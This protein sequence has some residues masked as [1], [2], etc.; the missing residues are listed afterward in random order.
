MKNAKM[1]LV[2]FGL[3][4][5]TQVAI[6]GRYYDAATGRFLTVDKLADK[7]PAWSPY[8]YVFNNPLA[9][10]DPDGN[11]PNKSQA[12]SPRKLIG[13]LQGVYKSYKSNARETLAYL[14]TYETL[15]GADP[16]NKRYL[17]S[18][19]GG[20]I[21]LVHFFNVA[22]EIDKLSN[23]EKV[24]AY[25]AGGFALWQETKNR[26]NDQA[27]Q[28]SIGT[29]WSYEDAPSNYLGFI[30]WKSYYNPDGDLISQII[31]FL[32]EY[33]ATDPGNAPNW[34]EM[35]TRENSKKQQFPQ[36]KGFFPRF[37]SEGD[38][39]DDWWSEYDPSKR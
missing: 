28:G 31:E 26:E 39:E 1:V 38:D 4:V 25:V 14:G 22:A 36:N 3:I 23:T 30:F 8:S 11:E 27:A 19:K 20:W 37:T 33:G 21:D 18:R 6:A 10:I 15:G 34:K 32:K 17:Y 16:A 29:A 12:T 9:Y 7:Y 24:G 13:Y 5:M 35:W 2:V